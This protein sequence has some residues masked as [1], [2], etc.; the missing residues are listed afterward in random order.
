[1]CAGVPSQAESGSASGTRG[2]RDTGMAT[3]TATTMTG[4]Q[5]RGGYGLRAE[6]KSSVPAFPTSQLPQARSSR[7][8]WGVETSSG[9]DKSTWSGS[10][11]KIQNLASTMLGST[12]DLGGEEEEK[13]RR[14]RIAERRRR[15]GLDTLVGARTSGA[16]PNAA[17]ATSCIRSRADV[18]GGESD[19]RA[20][21]RRKIEHGD[22][23]KSRS[24]PTPSVSTKLL[25]KRSTSP[26]TLLLQN[27]ASSS[28]PSTDRR[29]DILAYVHKVRPTDTLE[30][31]VIMYNI[32]PSAL[33]RANRLWM[34][35][36]IQWRKE[37]YLPVDECLTKGTPLTKEEEE[38]KNTQEIPKS[39]SSLAVV[40]ES[41]GVSVSLLPGRR[42]DTSELNDS[43]SKTDGKLPSPEVTANGITRS[44]ESPYHHH[45][46]V[47]IPAIGIVEIARLSRNKLS[48]FPPRGRGRGLSA[49]STTISEDVGLLDPMVGPA[50]LLKIGGK[51]SE[52]YTGVSGQQ[53]KSGGDIP[54]FGQMFNQVAR[55][56][57]GGVENMG[58]AVEGFVRKMVVKVGEMARDGTEAAI[59]LA[60]H[61]G[62]NAGGPGGGQRGGQGG[63]S[64]WKLGDRGADSGNSLGPS[65]ASSREPNMA[66][67]ILRGRKL[68][69]A[70]SAGPSRAGPGRSSAMGNDPSITRIGHER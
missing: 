8:A 5:L 26:E 7:Q 25:H 2:T 49:P 61:V 14:I 32:H 50:S 70:S 47:I 13:R 60:E 23:L 59:E 43:I 1:M 27:R 62:N 65:S 58:S 44:E 17:E 38:S 18:V 67:R 36:S 12:A 39:A 24:K 11:S 15:A 31:V 35:D 22:E 63:G 41:E 4:E 3:M 54:T 57:R 52:A 66:P 51:V 40:P 9:G 48:H 69:L 37:L 33:R 30:G 56:T 6:P 68:D 45:S 16:S 64:H 53:L 28:P 46:F 10:W 29:E 34:E 20:R 42:K 55:E 19:L 21:G